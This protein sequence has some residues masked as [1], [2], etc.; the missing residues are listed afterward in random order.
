MNISWN[1]QWKLN[2]NV[3]LRTVSF[4]DHN[5]IRDMV[6]WFITVTLSNF[7]NFE[8]LYIFHITLYDHWAVTVEQEIFTCL[9][10]SRIMRGGYPMGVGCPFY[11]H[12]GIES[13]PDPWAKWQKREKSMLYSIS[14]GICQLFIIPI[15]AMLKNTQKK[16]RDHEFDS[17][18][19][20]WPTL[21]SLFHL[22]AV[23][24]CGF[25]QWNIKVDTVNIYIKLQNRTSQNSFN[26]GRCYIYTV[27]TL[28]D[29]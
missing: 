9:K 25:W 20:C 19:W 7:W 12:F 15:H 16:I 1:I 28:W 3:F 2:S 27:I 24:A 29:L 23:L 13:V 4:S 21:L 26:G 10:I 17:I 14:K 22:D 8:I 5:L 11:G 6:I 18:L